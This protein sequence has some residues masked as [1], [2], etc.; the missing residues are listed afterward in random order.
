MQ[1]ECLVRNESKDAVLKL[2]V[3]FLHPMA[4]EVGRLSGAARR[5]ARG[6]TASV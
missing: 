2:S 1:T 5:A 4:R 3:R 6:D